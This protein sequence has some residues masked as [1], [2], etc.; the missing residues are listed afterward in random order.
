M[1]QHRTAGG[2]LVCGAVAFFRAWKSCT[3]CR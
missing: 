2:I 3:V 1:R